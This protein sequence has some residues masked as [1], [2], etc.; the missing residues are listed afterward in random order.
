MAKKNVDDFRNEPT[1]RSS[2]QL[3]MLLGPVSHSDDQS[4]LKADKKAVHP[5]W[6]YQFQLVGGVKPLNVVFRSP[7][8]C[9]YGY[10]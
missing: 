6:T 3:A 9:K 4:F 1:V 7:L 10:Y 5:V 2:V 8:W